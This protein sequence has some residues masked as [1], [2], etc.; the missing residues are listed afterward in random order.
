MIVISKTYAQRNILIR[1]GSSVLLYMYVR[2]T[3]TVG[4]RV[5]H[6]RFSNKLT[7]MCMIY[8]CY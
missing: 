4:K 8:A 6:L 5:S 1:G 3:S 7:T 2:E